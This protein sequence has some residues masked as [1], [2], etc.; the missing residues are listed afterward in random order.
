MENTGIVNRPSVRLTLYTQNEINNLVEKRVIEEIYFQFR[1]KENI[2]PFYENFQ[3]DSFLGSAIKRMWGA[4]KRL[5]PLYDLIIYSILLQNATIRRTVQ[6]LRNLLDNYGTKVAFDNKAVYVLWEPKILAEASESDLKKLKVGYRAKSLIRIS[7]SFAKGDISEHKLRRI[8]KE[9]A[10]K[11]LMGLH[12]I[13]PA[14]A[15]ILLFESLGYYD[16]RDYIPRW[17]QKIFSK[18][19]FQKELVP[20]R[21]ILDKLKKRYG[22]WKALAFYYLLEDLFWRHKEKRI[23]WLEKEIRL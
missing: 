10:K 11:E 13:G 1:F 23:D 2:L 4:R 19:L 12:G 21:I 3:S 18:L 7:E 9:K 17:E 16:A 15:D 8:G 6:M 22:R 20:A 14:S 5:S